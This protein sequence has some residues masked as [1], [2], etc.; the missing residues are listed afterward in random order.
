MY[1]ETIDFGTAITPEELLFIKEVTHPGD[2][3]YLPD[4]PTYKKAQIKKIY[5]NII[6]TTIGT[7][8][9]PDIV[10][11]YRYTV[12]KQNNITGGI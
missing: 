12:D 3:F 6:I 11:G 1:N 2:T 5:A 10:L 7:K 9:W 8:T 4:G